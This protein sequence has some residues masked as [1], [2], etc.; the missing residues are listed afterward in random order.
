MRLQ[1]HHVQR[2]ELHILKVAQFPLRH[3]LI[4]AAE[5]L[6]DVGP[7]IV[8]PAGQQLSRHL[9]RPFRLAGEQADRLGRADTIQHRVQRMGLQIG[10]VGFVPGFLDAGEGHLHTAD[11]RQHLEAV[12]AEL[13]AQVAG[14][15]V[16]ERVAGRQDRRALD[17]RGRR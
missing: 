2:R 12:L 16:E 17:D 10:Q 5:V 8:Q 13:F 14:H 6:A 9:G 7:E 1:D 15:A 4:A 3:A 11:V